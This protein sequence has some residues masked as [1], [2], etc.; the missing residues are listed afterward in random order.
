MKKRLSNGF[1]KGEK[2][3]QLDKK[4]W[5]RHGQFMPLDKP[6]DIYFDEIHKGGST[7]KAQDQ[8]LHAFKDRYTIDI[9]V[10]VTA[11]YAK[12]T[13]A[14]SSVLDTHKPII[15]NWSYSDQQNMKRVSNIQ[16]R[17][18]II[19][20]RDGTQKEQLERLFKDY[21]KRFQ[22]QYLDTLEEDYKKNPELVILRGRNAVGLRNIHKNTFYL[23]C[24]ANA[25]TQKQAQDPTEIFVNNKGVTRLI[26]SIGCYVKKDGGMILPESTLYGKLKYEFDYDVISTRHTQLWFLPY[27]NLY[28]DKCDKQ[29]RHHKKKKE[30][31]HR[32]RK[33][34]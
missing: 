21:E 32:R 31:Q 7:E 13:I 10:M 3:H 30:Y 15:L 24:S 33:R 12:P 25:E 20:S 28:V 23:K 19:E 2:N 11:T 8:I 18:K 4:F 1:V 26:D 16:I 17:N 9:F 34:R 29:R 14:Y 27:N 5:N 6:I 22:S